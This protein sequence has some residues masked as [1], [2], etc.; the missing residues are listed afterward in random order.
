MVNP[1]ATEMVDVQ[2]PTQAQVSQV[3]SSAAIAETTTNSASA[4]MNGVKDAIQKNVTVYVQSFYAR[5]KGSAVTEELIE[6]FL[7][8][9]LGIVDGEFIGGRK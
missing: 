8:R 3:V 7:I 9:I 4:Q 1:V 6:G 2:A 5:N